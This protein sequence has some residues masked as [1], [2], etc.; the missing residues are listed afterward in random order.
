MSEKYK[1]FAA[2][3]GDADV[4]AFAR[5]VRDYG[6]GGGNHPVRDWVSRHDPAASA[7]RLGKRTQAPQYVGVVH[8]IGAL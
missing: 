4:D 2:A 8:S 6:E 5:R 7:L 3:N 1:A